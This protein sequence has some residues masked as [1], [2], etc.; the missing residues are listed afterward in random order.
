MYGL[1]AIEAA[2]GWVIAG[3]G[4]A[5]VYTGLVVLYAFTS[6]LERILSLLDAGSRFRSAGKSPE[7]PGPAESLPPSEQPCPD[8]EETLRLTPQQQEAAV[9]FELIAKRL[10]EPFSLPLLLEQAE[11][12][13]IPHPFRHLDT[14]LGIGLIEECEGQWAGFYRF[15]R[16][17]PY[18]NPDGV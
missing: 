5:I 10:G 2:N 17:C 9:Y 13:G 12:R 1:E 7:I 11:K 4:I 15:R 8:E 3:V 16:D 14:F 18:Y 6:N